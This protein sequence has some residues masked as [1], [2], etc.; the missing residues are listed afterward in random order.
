[1]DEPTSVLTPLEVETLFATLRRLVSEGCSILYISHKLEE[2][3]ALCD[4]A[5]IL[6]GGKV[7]AMC[8][9][10]QETARNLARDDDRHACRAAAA[11]GEAPS[12]RCA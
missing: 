1:M 8:D 9:P 2:I 4:R 3:R 12:A 7:V 6:R 10:R 11:R 5:T